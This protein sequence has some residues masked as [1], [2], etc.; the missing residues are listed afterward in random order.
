[1]SELQNALF[2]N[3]TNI[4]YSLS[5]YS[6]IIICVSIVLFSMLS[7]TMEKAFVFFVW[8]FIITFIRIIVFTGL[9]TNQGSV[10]N[11]MPNICL[12]GL[13]NLFIPKD[14]TYSTFILTFTMMYFVT[15]MIMISKQNNVNVINYGMLA[16]FLAYIALDLFIKNV[17]SCIQLFSSLVIGDVLSGLFLG[18][19]ISGIIM[20]GSTLKSYLYINEINTNKEVCL[21]PSKQQFKCRVF[22]DGTLVGNI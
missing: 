7:S 10:P 9:N 17:L 2:N 21:M 3:T 13:S 20:Y 19:V 4:F 5:F 15:P 22:K 8:I 6:P 16:F 12:T 14:V 11:E 18:G 1:M